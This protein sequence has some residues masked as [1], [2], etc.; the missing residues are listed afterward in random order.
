MRF[1]EF[2]RLLLVLNPLVRPDLPRQLLA[3]DL[4]QVHL[5]L[6]ATLVILFQ[7][8]VPLRS[9]FLFLIKLLLINLLL[10]NSVVPVHVIE[11]QVL[12]DL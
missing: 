6:P 1:A 7:R 5:R 4:I 3:V 2:F 12:L 11:V 8:L 10:R 9:R